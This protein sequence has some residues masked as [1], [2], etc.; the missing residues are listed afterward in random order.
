MSQAINSKG[1]LEEGT[2]GLNYLKQ[3]GYF[4]N[5]DEEDDLIK[6]FGIMGLDT[7]INKHKIRSFRVSA[8]RP[9]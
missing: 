1:V 8:Q 5:K 3:N 2:N 9:D 7:K 4:W 6:I